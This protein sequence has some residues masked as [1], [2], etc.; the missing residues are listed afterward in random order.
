MK[1][2]AYAKINW[3]LYI[4]SVRPDGYHELDS[5]MQPISLCDTVSVELK[6]PGG[7]STLT[8]DGPFS[9]GVPTDGSNLAMKAANVYEEA[10]GR[11]MPV[12]IGVTK[13][14]P[15]GA[16]L[17]GGSADA[18]AVLRAMNALNGDALAP[19][20]L[21]ALALRLG[22]DVPFCLR[23]GAFRARGIGEELEAFPMPGGAPILL[24]MGRERLDTGRVYR[25][26]DMGGAACDPDKIALSRA[27]LQRG[28]YARYALEAQNMLYPPA[29]SLAAGL[30]EGIDDLKDLGAVFSAMTGS[31]AA[32][33]GVF[34]SEADALK[35][36]EHLK[37]KYPCCLMAHTGTL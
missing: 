22:A 37:E 24:I 11:P 31:G 4:T 14:I 33:F 35:A 25:R 34:A 27:F 15:N 3:D 20:R 13:A 23:T 16:G 19:G 18:A 7:E 5:V 12:S 2:N 21:D 9:A 28:D 26:F 36:R 30:Q 17:G 10:L 6:G 32:L 8:V 1:I 29:L